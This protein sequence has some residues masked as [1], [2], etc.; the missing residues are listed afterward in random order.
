[1]V[2]NYL[3]LEPEQK[4]VVVIA[5]HKGYAMLMLLAR[6]GDISWTIKEIDVSSHDIVELW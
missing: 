2:D 1:M 6:Y 4:S 5:E 3:S